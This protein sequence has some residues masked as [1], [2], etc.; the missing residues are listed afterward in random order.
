MFPAPLPDPPDMVGTLEIVAVFILLQ[1][2]ALTGRLACLAAFG[3][4]AIALM[5]GVAR[6]LTEENGAVRAPALLDSCG[7]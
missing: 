1:P 7:H 2:S 4:G 5:P 6:I 3:L